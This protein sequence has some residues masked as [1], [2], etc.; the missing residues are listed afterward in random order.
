[1]KH[2]DFQNIPGE[3][4][5]D[6]LNDERNLTEEKVDDLLNQLLKDFKEEEKGCCSL[7]DKGWPPTFSAY[8]VSKAAVNAYTRILAK[9]YPDFKVNCVCPGFVKTD[10]NFNT[11]KLTIDEG[12]ASAVRLAL[13]PDDG[14]SGLFFDRE[15]LS[16]F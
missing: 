1:M 2:L 12:A 15:E 3:W 16:S 10:M 7:E 8:T 4:I 5:R 11:G 13:L 9:K 14:P 6:V